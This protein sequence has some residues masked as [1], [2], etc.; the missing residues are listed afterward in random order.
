MTD[1]KYDNGYICYFN[2]QKW[3]CRAPSMFSAHEKAVLHFQPKKSQKHMVHCV[4]AER[5][6]GEAV[7]H[8]TSEFG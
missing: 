6:N 1:S 8:S 4:L 5:A 2:N 3:E 7:T